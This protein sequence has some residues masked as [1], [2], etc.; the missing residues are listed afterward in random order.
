MR[1]SGKT[2]LSGLFFSLAVLSSCLE[3]AAAEN[4]IFLT[5]EIQLKMADV[6]LGEGEYYRAVTEYKKFL[7][8]FPDSE[9]ADYALFQT[10]RAYYD[11][12]EY[13]S[14]GRS[15]LSVREKYPGGPYVLKAYYFEG[16]SAWKL[17]KPEQAQALFEDLAGAFPDSEY[18]PLALAAASL[19]ALDR[20]DIGAGKKELEQFCLRYPAHP[21]MEK[22]GEALLLFDQYEK[23]PRKSPILAAVM[24]ALLPGSGYLY[25]EHY[26]DGLTAF[27]INALFI[28]GSI[29]AVHQ[30]NYAVAG[31]AGGLGLPFYVGNI[32]GSAN[33]AQKWNLNARREVRRKIYQALDF[34]F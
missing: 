32:Y 8:L 22:V 24:S 1:P 13:A 16:L 2:L 30:E 11:G 33:A 18:A 20:E 23:L 7:I 12:G 31:L 17:D 14:S 3:P 28:A 27:L 10:G 19:A 26:G 15:F 4:G 34:I 5:E 6:F 21:R 29:T 25:A 9:R